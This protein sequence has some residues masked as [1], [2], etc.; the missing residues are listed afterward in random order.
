MKA[1]F[2]EIYRLYARRLYLFIYGK[3][4]NN[5]LAED[6]MQTTFL[7]AIMH[8]DNFREESN[9]YTWLCRIAINTLAS[10]MNLSEHNNTSLEE[11]IEKGILNFAKQN[12]ED[13]LSMLIKKDE[14][15]VLY[16]SIN[17]LNRD[18]KQVILMRL[19]GLRFKEIGQRLNKSEGWA[20]MNY[21][22]AI[23]SLRK[24]LIK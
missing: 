9:I 14:V 3:C 22:R 20:K 19:H 10:E 5:E 13:P 7:K 8:I 21:K 23:N 17:N 12:E 16:R 24:D 4:R 11:T 1:D 6:V 18:K 15:S 2:N